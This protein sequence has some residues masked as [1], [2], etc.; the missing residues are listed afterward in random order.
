MPRVSS[1]QVHCKFEQ[2]SSQNLRKNDV[3]LLSFLLSLWIAYLCIL[4]PMLEPPSLNPKDFDHILHPGHKLN[5]SEA[6]LSTNELTHEIEALKELLDV[7]LLSP[8]FPN[9]STF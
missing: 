3:N 8:T 5:A 4:V 2:C 6:V 7:L 1:F 9:Q